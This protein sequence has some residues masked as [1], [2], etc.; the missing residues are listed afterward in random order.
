VGGDWSKTLQN[1][2]FRST[3]IFRTS[4]VPPA[5]RGR[6]LFNSPSALSVPMTTLSS[7][8][9]AVY[10]YIYIYILYCWADDDYLFSDICL[11]LV[12][13]ICVQGTCPALHVKIDIVIILTYK[14]THARVSYNNNNNNKWCLT[15][16]RVQA[17]DE[18]FPSMPSCR[19]HGGWAVCWELGVGEHTD[20]YALWR[21]LVSTCVYECT[22]FWINSQQYIYIVYMCVCVC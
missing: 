1:S 18:G 22:L 19:R 5:G 9:S 8:P 16:T 21:S 10:I 14:H 3:T 13:Y 11:S 4:L 15:S 20:T 6:Y 17:D 2:H 7:M 12:V